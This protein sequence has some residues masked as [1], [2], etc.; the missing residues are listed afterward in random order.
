V[1][2]SDDQPATKPKAVVGELFALH[3]CS[4]DSIAACSKGDQILGEPFCS[5]FFSPTMMKQNNL[6]LAADNL[7]FFCFADTDR[8][9]E[10]PPPA[11]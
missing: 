10:A 5:L 6:N 2:V 11:K 4:N 8:E 7:Y 9:T 1:L 3:D